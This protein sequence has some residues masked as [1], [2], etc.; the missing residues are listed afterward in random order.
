[1]IVLREIKI[2]LGISLL[3]LKPLIIL[4]SI[5]LD[6]ELGCEFHKDINKF[7]RCDMKNMK[8]NRHFI[9]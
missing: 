9:S 2:M 4:K 5:I 7:S 1:M 8:K 6:C 3:L